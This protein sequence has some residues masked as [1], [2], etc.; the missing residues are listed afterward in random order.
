M[1]KIGHG[2]NKNRTRCK[3]F[4]SDM[5]QI[6]PGKNKERVRCIRMGIQYTCKIKSK[7]RKIE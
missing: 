4:G 5:N 3:Y 1:N 2:M 7:S 6:G